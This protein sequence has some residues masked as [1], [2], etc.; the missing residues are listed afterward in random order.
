MAAHQLSRPAMDLGPYSQAGGVW[1]VLSCWGNEERANTGRTAF[2]CDR[3][4]GGKDGAGKK[5]SEQESRREVE[6]GWHLRSPT[7][8]RGNKKW[9]FPREV[10]KRFRR[11][12]FS[13]WFERVL[14]EHKLSLVENTVPHIIARRSFE[15]RYGRC[16]LGLGQRTP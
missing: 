7:I 10:Y 9:P 4:I 5:F 11:S 6:L 12:R 16:H 13:M 8:L 14:L 15:P 2:R 3:I 1:A